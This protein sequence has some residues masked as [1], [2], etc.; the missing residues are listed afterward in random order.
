VTRAGRRGRAATT[1]GEAA[2]PAGGPTLDAEVAERDVE[3]MLTHVAEDLIRTVRHPDVV[4]L[5]RVLIAEQPLHRSSRE[6]AI[7]HGGRH[8][9]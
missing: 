5:R 7:G 3:T 9:P 4:G 2:R 1:T 6:L 8:G